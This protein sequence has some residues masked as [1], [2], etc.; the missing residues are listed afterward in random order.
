MAI[1]HLPQV[2]IALWEHLEAVGG[3][4]ES[5]DVI[6]ALAQRFHISP[7]E[8]EM[9]DPTGNRTFDHRVH[10]AVAQSRIVGWLEPVNE[11]GRGVWKLTSAYLSDDPLALN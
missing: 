7:V 3:S 1:P 8:R 6:E 9:R 4:G 11:A 10:S 5:K 2:R